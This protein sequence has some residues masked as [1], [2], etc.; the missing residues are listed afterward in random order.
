MLYLSV[1]VS[2]FDLMIC[3]MVLMHKLRIIVA[4]YLFLF[5]MA[6]AAS[7][8]RGVAVSDG[9]SAMAFLTF[10]FALEYRFMI[11]YHLLAFF[12]H[13][14]VVTFVT[15]AHSG[16]IFRLLEMAEEAGVLSDRY[17]LSLHYLRV[18]ACTSKLFPSSEVFQ[19]RLMIE[20]NILLEYHYP[21]ECSCVVASS[22]QAAC[23]L[24]L[25]SW[26]TL[27]INSCEVINQ[28]GEGGE[29]ALDFARYSWREVAV[30]A[31]DFGM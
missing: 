7:F 26:F 22:S 18:A 15:C 19:V 11:I 24:D 23:V 6:L 30:G 14:S 21:F 3:N 25:R 16:K 28:H 27:L 2:A 31:G 5:S 13:W 4:L 12:S 29:F 9:H 1:T 10:D 17:M 8:F 20:V